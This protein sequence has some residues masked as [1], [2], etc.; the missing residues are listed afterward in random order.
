[1]TPTE[2]RHA[3]ACMSQWDKQTHFVALCADPPPHALNL[4]QSRKR[5]K[6][7]QRMSYK[8]RKGDALLSKK[9]SKSDDPKGLT[10]VDRMLNMRIPDE[11][12]TVDS[13]MKS[14]LA[15][16][17]GLAANDCGYC[18]SIKELVCN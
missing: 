5:M 17:I 6:Y 8:R 7:R 14:S 3:K 4:R 2:F 16:F 18:G 10:L 12:I 15:P 11:S 1:M 13:L 9:H